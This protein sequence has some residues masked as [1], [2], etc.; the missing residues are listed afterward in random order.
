L[1]FIGLHGVKSQKIELFISTDVRT[2]YLIFSGKSFTG[3]QRV[4]LEVI[5]KIYNEDFEVLAAAVIG[6]VVPVL[7]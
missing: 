6:K 3:K 2:S 5:Y 4:Y 7:N 1:T